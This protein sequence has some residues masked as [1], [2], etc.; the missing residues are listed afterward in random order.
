MHSTMPPKPE[1]EGGPTWSI[2]TWSL[3]YDERIPYSIEEI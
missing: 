1:V 3:E 2:G